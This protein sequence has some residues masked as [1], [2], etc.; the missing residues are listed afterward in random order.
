MLDHIGEEFEAT[1]DSML[2]N[3]FFVQTDNYIDGRV[4]MMMRGEEEVPLVGYYQYNENLM[5]YTR[6]NRV[7]LRYGDRVIVKCT[8]SDPDAREID[9][10]LVRKE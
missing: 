3:A 6:N 5:A 4:D 2:S 8:A 1:I 9:F 7:D 10:T